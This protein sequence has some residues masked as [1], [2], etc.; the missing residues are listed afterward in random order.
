MVY[1]VVTKNGKAV[2][3]MFEQSSHKIVD[4]DK[5]FLCSNFI[6]EIYRSIKEFI[7]QSAFKGYDFRLKKGDIKY[8]V[9]REY[10]GQAIVTIVSSKNIDIKPLYDYLHSRYNTIGLSLVITNKDEEIMSGKYKHIAGIDKLEI[11]E[12]GIKYKIDI[13]S[14]VKDFIVMIIK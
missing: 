4:I 3:G 10:S 5:C 12:F 1:P 7:E 6:N 11:K 14:V 13:K 9:I 8:V 2:V